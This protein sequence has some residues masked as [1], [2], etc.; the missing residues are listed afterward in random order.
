MA[1]SIMY[2]APIA[3]EPMQKVKSNSIVGKA[4][5]DRKV[6]TFLKSHPEFDWTSIEVKRAIGARRVRSVSNS[7]KRLVDEGKVVVVRKMS[8][9]LW[10]YQLP[11]WLDSDGDYNKKISGEMT[12]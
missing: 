8:G 9:K 3:K 1:T 10:S 11:E 5:V 7:L 12:Q 4:I 6:L 2:I